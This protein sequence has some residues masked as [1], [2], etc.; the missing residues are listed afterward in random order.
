MADITS[1]APKTTT[2]NLISLL[3]APFRAIGNGLISLAEAGPRM[4]EVRKL[5]ALTDE[6]LASRGTSRERE[7]RRIFASS[8]YL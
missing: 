1:H 5:N 8:L 7:I 4:A 2:A 6:Q 3:I